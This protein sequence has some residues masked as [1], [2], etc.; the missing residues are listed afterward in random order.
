MRRRSGSPFRLAGLLLLS[1]CDRGSASS[2]TDYLLT[3]S[4]TLPEDADELSSHGLY[5]L[6]GVNRTA[7]A[8]D[9]SRAFD[10]SVSALERA[11]RHDRARW[12][13]KSPFAPAISTLFAALDGNGDGA[14]SATEAN[15]V[16]RDLHADVDAVSSAPS[17]GRRAAT[18]P[19]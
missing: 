17:R 4:Q 10:A 12:F 11:L 16:L 8:D 7:E 19:V 13:D 15:E 2:L 6:L 1:L 5:A 14:L 18:L 3:A 9:V